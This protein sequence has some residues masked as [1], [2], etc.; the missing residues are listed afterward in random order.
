MKFLRQLLLLAILVYGLTG[1]DED[2]TNGCGN[3]DPGTVEF[4]DHSVFVENNSNCPRKVSVGSDPPKVVEAFDHLE[5]KLQKASQTI[6]YSIDKS[7]CNGAKTESGN[8]KGGDVVLINS[9][10][11][12]KKPR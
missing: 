12:V 11:G 7:N 5:I 9:D 2:G 6:F 1:C 4:H 3:G 10:G 8:A